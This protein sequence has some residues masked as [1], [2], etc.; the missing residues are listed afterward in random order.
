MCIFCVFPYFSRI[1]LLI[2]FDE[3]YVGF[4]CFV[5]FTVICFYLEGVGGGVSLSEKNLGSRISN[6]TDFYG[7]YFISQI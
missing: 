5:A 3:I 4:R 1:L 6:L 2:N 7:D